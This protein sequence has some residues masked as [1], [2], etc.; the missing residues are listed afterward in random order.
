MVFQR[1]YNLDVDGK[2]NLGEDNFI[3][4]GSTFNKL[5]EKLNGIHQDVDIYFITHPG[6]MAKFPK[7]VQ[8]HAL[9]YLTSLASAEDYLA[10]K[11]LLDNLP[12][13]DNLGL[14]W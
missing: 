8:K 4:T 12:A 5:M 11:T 3:C 9:A 1:G 6:A 14:I 7:I 10:V 13:D 2:D